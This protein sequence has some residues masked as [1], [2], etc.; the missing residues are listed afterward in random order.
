MAELGAE[1][2]RYHREIGR[3]RAELGVD[4]LLAVGEL[5]RGYLDGAALR[6]LGRDVDEAL[7]RVDA[8]VEPGDGVLVKAR[9]PSASRRSRSALDRRDR[10]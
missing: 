2:P 6:T 8:I 10:A 5:A 4:A 1:A 9:A 7:R 3:P